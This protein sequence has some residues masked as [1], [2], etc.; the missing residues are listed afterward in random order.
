MF[1]SKFLRFKS[2][3]KQWLAG[4]AMQ[5]ESE[6]MYSPFANSYLPI[7]YSVRIKE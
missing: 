2:N 5:K 4:Y 1:N 6:L 3:E 7:T